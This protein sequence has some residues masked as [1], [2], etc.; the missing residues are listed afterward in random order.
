MTASIAVRVQPGA[1]KEGL[2]GWTDDGALR[3]KVAAPPEGGRANR[4]VVDLLASL[5]G[6]PRRQ[7]VVVRGASS[8][9]KLIRVEGLDEPTVSGRLEA[10][11]DA[12]KGRNDQ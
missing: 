2:V 6:V 12:A 3:L 11:L 10:A 8:R 7:V 4:A 1:R 5:L 9:S